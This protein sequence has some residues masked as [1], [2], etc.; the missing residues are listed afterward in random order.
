MQSMQLVGQCRNP[1]SKATQKLP[2]DRSSEDQQCLSIQITRQIGRTQKTVTDQVKASYSQYQ[3]STQNLS[4]LSNSEI[5]K[6]S[7]QHK[8]QDTQ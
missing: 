1:I 6:Q 3:T 4:I 7:S 5:L 8:V 2:K